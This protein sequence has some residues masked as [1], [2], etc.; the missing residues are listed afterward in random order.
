MYESMFRDYIAECIER[1]WM[2]ECVDDNGDITHAWT[3]DGR[4][5]AA[6]MACD[7]W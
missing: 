2:V 3:D 6:P 1:G 7:E 5:A 4:M